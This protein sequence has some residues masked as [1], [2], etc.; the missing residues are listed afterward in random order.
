L[1]SFEGIRKELTN[2]KRKHDQHLKAIQKLRN[3]FMFKEGLIK[4]EQAKLQG[5]IRDMLRVG[6][7]GN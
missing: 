7:G 2:L 6:G 5:M 1:T 4:E 3:S